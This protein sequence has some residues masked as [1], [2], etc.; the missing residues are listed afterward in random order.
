MY[1]YSGKIDILSNL[2]NLAPTESIVVPKWVVGELKRISEKFGKPAMAGR[3]GI[4]YIKLLE[5]KKLIREVSDDECDRQNTFIDEK[6]LCLARKNR[7]ILCTNDKNMIRWAKNN[8]LRVIGVRA[9]RR[10]DFI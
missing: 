5:K 6:I 8:K 3:F 1:A 10:L 2:M 9:D 4:K 7:W